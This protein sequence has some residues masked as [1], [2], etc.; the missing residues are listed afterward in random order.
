MKNNDLYN[1]E[2]INDKELMKYYGYKNRLG[3][4]KMKFKLL[5]N[6]IISYCAKISPSPDLT[7]KLQRLRGV[8]IGNH[9]YIGPGT[10]IDLLYPQLIEI[11]DYVSIGMNSMIFAHSNPTCSINIKNE[12][13]PRTIKK[14]KI[15]R[16]SWIPPG[17]I[18]L[19][20]VTIGP[21][22]IVGAGSVVIKDV[23]KES[24]YA[25]TPAK[26]IRDLKYKS[27]L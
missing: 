2:K 12:L 5:L 21:D 17:C 16:G 18:I 23:E 3:T 25:G 1:P 15:L 9:V 27:K 8:S 19:P 6:Y 11:Q 14:V 13:Y 20:G 24:F 4:I 7:V 10:E 22:S 26:K